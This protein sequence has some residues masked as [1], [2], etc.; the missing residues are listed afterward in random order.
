MRFKSAK[1]PLSKG[2][3]SENQVGPVHYKG[4]GHNSSSVAQKKGCPVITARDRVTTE[5]RDSI[6]S[7][8]KNWIHDAERAAWA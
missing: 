2:N 7:S 4:L 5:E 1:E 8:T 6:F 3:S